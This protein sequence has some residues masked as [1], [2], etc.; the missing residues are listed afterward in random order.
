MRQLRRRT[1]SNKVTATVLLGLIASAGGVACGDDDTQVESGSLPNQAGMAGSGGS[2]STGNSAGS[3]NNAGADGAEDV[4]GAAGSSSAGAGSGVTPIFA[5]PT[6]AA[7]VRNLYGL[8]YSN[9]GEQAGKLYASG[10]G[11]NGNVVLLRLAADGALDAS[12][13]DA[14]MVDT[15]SAGNSYGVVELASGDLIVQGNG[16]GQVFLVK[17]S[18]A[19]EL[20]AS[21]GRVAVLQWSAADLEAIDTACASA[22][23]AVEDTELA[24]ACTALWPAAVAPMFNLRPAYTSWDIQLETVTGAGTEKIVV[25]AHGAPPRA[26]SGVQRTDD[27]R[28]ITRVLAS[29]GSPDPDF[30]AGSPFSVDV[31]GLA[32]SD[33]GRRGLVES[34]G[35]LISAGYTNFGEGNNGII[36]RLNPDGTPDAS[37]GFDTEAEP[38]TLQPGLTRFN[39]FV[40]P[41]AAAEVYSVVKQESG[42]YVTTG[43]GVSNFN[44]ST[45][46]NDLLSFGLTPSGL[47]PVWGEEGAAVVQSEVDQSVIE[48][49]TWDGGRAFRENGRDLLLLA[50]GRTLQVGCYND[51]A[52]VVVF[53]PDGALDESFGTGGKLVFDA[54]NETTHTAPFFAVTQSVDGRIAASASGNFVAI[55]DVP[56]SD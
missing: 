31:A 45:I 21:F 25:F 42:R 15:G 26:E 9:V 44:I 16:D 48:A 29:D 35:S 27:D 18:S 51:F 41:D 7:G 40:G 20:D 47:D 56:A 39:P 14:G 30:N 34:D 37:F 46:E 2:A 4:G 19:G 13:G 1:A 38:S 8:V 33:G 54:A 6:A 50:D 3:G 10:V 22:A 24:A 5:G 32:A 52:S 17:I 36:I 12:F 55:F 11:E 28:W 23:A 49:G 43:Y 53:G